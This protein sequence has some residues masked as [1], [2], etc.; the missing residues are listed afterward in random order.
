MKKTDTVVYTNTR[1]YKYKIQLFT[2]LELKDMMSRKIA[3]SLH[4]KSIFSL[5]LNL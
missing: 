2:L 4:L 5:T 3:D 1:T